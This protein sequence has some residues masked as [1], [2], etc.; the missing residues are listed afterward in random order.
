MPEDWLNLTSCQ[1]A[2][3][4]ARFH[5]E[6]TRHAE[7]IPPT[8]TANI[9]DIARVLIDRIGDG[10]RDKVLQ[11]LL[12]AKRPTDCRTLLPLSQIPFSFCTGVG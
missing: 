1:I 2:T 10:E 7:A 6:V 3:Y 9:P 11:N 4:P 5:L 12:S 8:A